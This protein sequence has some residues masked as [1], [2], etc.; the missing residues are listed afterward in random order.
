MPDAP[1]SRRSSQR[2]R[3][4]A[5][6][7]WGIMSQPVKG[8]PDDKGGWAAKWRKFNRIANPDGWGS[9][10]NF[11]IPCSRAAIVGAF[12]PV[13]LLGIHLLT[14]RTLTLG[15]WTLILLTG[16]PIWL[17]PPLRALYLRRR[18]RRGVLEAELYAQDAEDP[19]D[20]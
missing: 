16:L 13:V 10:I 1:R 17:I 3:R 6:D 12:L 7:G 5:T 11:D 4:G 20:D 18:A 2:T 19:E 9:E 8:S 15:A 14:G